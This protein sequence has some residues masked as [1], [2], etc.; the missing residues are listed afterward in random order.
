MIVNIMIYQHES[1][2]LGNTCRRTL[3]QRATQVTS[4]TF[5]CRLFP[6]VASIEQM[7]SLFETPN[8]VILVVSSNMPEL[9]VSP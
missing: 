1:K 7:A 3:L 4:L 2:L 5:R 9:K 8:Y 6:L